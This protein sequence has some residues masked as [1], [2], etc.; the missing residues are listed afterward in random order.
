MISVR[1]RALF[2]QHS[3]PEE[4]SESY[5]RSFCLRSFLL[6]ICHMFPPR[7]V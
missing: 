4:R 3:T 6:V 2:S 5:W 1:S 7:S